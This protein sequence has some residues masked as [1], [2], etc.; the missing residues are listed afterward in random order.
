MT[1]MTATQSD[2]IGSISNQINTLNSQGLLNSITNKNQRSA[3]T[4]PNDSPINFNQIESCIN[5]PDSFIRDAT[6]DNPDSVDVMLINTLLNGGTIGELADTMAI[7]SPEM[8]AEYVSACAESINSFNISVGRSVITT[9]DLRSV[10][11]SFLSDSTTARSIFEGN[12]NQDTINWYYGM[13]AFT[14]GGLSAYRWCGWWQPWVGVA[15]VITAVAGGASMATQLGIWYVCTDFQSWVTSL[16][17]LNGASLTSMA[18]GPNGLKLLGISAATAG[19]V[20]FCAGVTPELWGIVVGNVTSTWN[21]IITFL[22]KMLPGITLVIQG[23][24]LKPI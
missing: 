3:L 6:K 18:N 1:K 2:T 10:K 5:D 19:V 12:L 8:S 13:C 7:V 4:L 15:G 21:G 16:A 23:V 24:Q 17:G 9:Q 20:G 22:N 11:L 14:I